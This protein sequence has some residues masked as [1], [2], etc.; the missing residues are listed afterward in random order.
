MKLQVV[1][2]KTPGD[3]NEEGLLKQLKIG[4]SNS[5]FIACHNGS[6]NVTF[7]AELFVKGVDEFINGHGLINIK[8]S[9]R[10]DAYWVDGFIF[11]PKVTRYVEPC[12]AELLFPTKKDWVQK[13]FIYVDV[14]GAK[15]VKTPKNRN[16]AE[17]T[18]S[19]SQTISRVK[20]GNW[21]VI[22]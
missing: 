10:M 15:L 1:I 16:I 19:R 22:K 6:L 3:G 5:R 4:A 2:L 17:L 9:D 18:I 12:F 13:D 14:N 7:A 20:N 8:V 21:L 11:V